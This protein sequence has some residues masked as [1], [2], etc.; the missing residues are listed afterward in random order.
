MRNFLNFKIYNYNKLYYIVLILFIIKTITIS[1]LKWLVLTHPGIYMNIDT[2]DTLVLEWL[3]RSGYQS[4][5][6]KL[7]ASNSE[8]AK[9]SAGSLLFRAEVIKLIRRGFI[10]ESIE[11][12]QSQG[13]DSNQI[14][15]KEIIFLLKLQ[16][17]IELLRQRNTVAAVAWI[18]NSVM[19]TV[20]PVFEPVLQDY[21]GILAYAEPE[22]SPL[23]YFFEKR[24]RYAHLAHTVNT[25]LFNLTS[26]DLVTTSPPIEILLKQVHAVNDLVYEVGGFSNDIEDRKWSV[27][28][29]LLNH[30]KQKPF[31]KTIKND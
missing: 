18:K 3:I 31:V 29:N 28:Q 5:F 30:P 8:S 23:A 6:N 10:L 2:I 19:P 22:S 26:G 11:L 21:L 24:D 25:A 1:P 17:F 13:L 7:P 15:L 14:A 12:I 4:T 27:I 9:K 20:T 16:H